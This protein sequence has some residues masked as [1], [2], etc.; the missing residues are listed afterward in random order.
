MAGENQKSSLKDLLDRMEKAHKADI[1]L[2]TSGHL[3]HD[4]LYKPQQWKK[5]NYW[6][7]AKKSALIITKRTNYTTPS[8]VSRKTKTT[9]SSCVDSTPTPTRT[10]S[11]S[12][13]C[14][15]HRAFKASYRSPVSTSL[16]STSFK[17]QR[18]KDAEEAKEELG[19]FQR[20]LIREELEVP[21]MRTLKYKPTINSRL[22]AMEETKD[23]YQ[24]FPSYL[25][26]VTKMDQFHKFMQFQKDV[27]AKQDL[28]KNDF[29]GSDSA[30]HHERTLAQALRNI[31]DCSR[32]HFNRLQAVGDVFEDICNSSLIFG[33][34]L[35]EVKNEYELYMV[36]LLESLPTMQYRTLQNEVKGMEK[37]AAMTH[38]VEENRQ[39]VQ[40]LVQ[41][42][43][44]ALARNEELRN[45]LEMELWMSQS[46]EKMAEKKRE[47]LSKEELPALSSTEKLVSLRCQVITTWEEIQVMQK[48]IKET[49]AVAGIANIR[50][51]TVKELE[52]EA[53]KLQASNKFLKRQI[54][55]A[56]QSVTSTL[57]R[58]KFS[59]KSQRNLW[60]MVQDF[61]TPEGTERLFAP[62]EESSS[63]DSL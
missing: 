54:G 4:K 6:G 57:Q 63:D 53:S 21:E 28:L 41:K 56:V 18:K 1:Q 33:D 45:E 58:Q 40:D 37:R 34:I 62:L 12:H 59:E 50:E 7:S 42:S 11:A 30:E 35:K 19:I 43:R 2:Y 22:C 9:L 55:D 39:E 51:K 20:Q 8:V 46:Y 31:C 10:K 3:N 13:S 14:F 52:G 17:Q 5:N 24:F 44:L 61:L 49:M 60:G 15:Q 16:D 47:D 29:I 27:I 23:E 36:I 32:P 26:G 48:E 38:E 25:A